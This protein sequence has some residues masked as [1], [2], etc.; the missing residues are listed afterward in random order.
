MSAKVIQFPI[1]VWPKPVPSVE[2]QLAIRTDRIIQ[3]IMKYYVHELTVG[4]G[5]GCDAAK[6]VLKAGGDS[7]SAWAAAEH[8]IV[9][10][11]EKVLREAVVS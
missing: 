7:E 2:E 10:Y 9:E 6:I 4:V 5:L 11:R 3:K 1:V 8:A